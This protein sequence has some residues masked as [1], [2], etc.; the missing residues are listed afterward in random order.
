VRT[1]TLRV[2]GRA[3][4]WL[5][6]VVAVVLVAGCDYEV[7]G[8]SGQLDPAFGGGDGVVS[9]AGRARSDDNVMAAT[10]QPDGKLVVVTDTGGDFMLLRFLPGGDIDPGFGD[11]GV[12]HTA[13]PNGIVTAVTVM[14]DG[15]IALAGGIFG[16][17]SITGWL[18]AR[19]QPD[20]DP[21]PGF[22]NGG[23]ARVLPD[24]EPAVPFGFATDIV[25][26]GDDIVIAAIRTS[27]GG[28]PRN[29]GV[30][31]KL[32]ADGTIDTSFGPDGTGTVIVGNASRGVVGALPD[33]SFVA[34]SL[35]DGGPA[36]LVL[37][38]ATGVASPPIGL[39]AGS[40]TVVGWDDIAVAGDGS[41]VV[42]GTELVFPNRSAVLVKLAPD[43]TLDTGFGAG[44]VAPVPL[45]VGRQASV[46]V[47]AG[48]LVV[49]A[50]TVAPDRNVQTARVTDAG[51]LD[52]AWGDGGMATYD[53]TESG[54]AVVATGEGVLVI[55]A[56]PPFSAG[57]GPSD[58]LL[59]A[60]D[61][62][63]AV[64]P[65]F[66]D[67]GRVAYDI[68][69]PGFDT[70]TVTARLPGGDILVAGDTR[71]GVVAGR[72]DGHGMPDDDHPVAPLLPGRLAGLH[73]VRDLAVAPDGSAFLL[74]Q[75]GDQ[76]PAAFFGGGGT[77]WRVVKLAPGGEIDTS[78]GDGGV[79]VHDGGS[80]PNAIA[81]QP[82]GTVLVAWTVIH[83][84]RLIPPHGVEPATFDFRIDALTPS[85]QPDTTFGTGGSLLHPFTGSPGPPGPPFTGWMAVGP[86][87]TAYLS[88]VGL[89]RVDP[90]GTAFTPGA[91]AGT[92]LGAT[93]VAIDPRGGVV[94]T[95]RA[96]VG[97]T[98]GVDVV[99]R[100]NADLT[101]LDPAF[102]TA[103]LAPL[104]PTL[105]GQVL[106][107]P[108]LL[109]DDHGVVTV[110][111]QARATGL[112][113][114]DLVIRRMTARGVPDAGFSSDGLAVGAFAPGGETA[115]VAGAALVGRDVV[116]VGRFTDALDGMVAR[117]NG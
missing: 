58:V 80:F 76:E 3:S 93:D 55:G 78:F 44:G 29:D 13:I 68:G 56:T 31:A 75:V 6:A 37:V 27:D 9:F 5:A 10:R 87:G 79:A 30:V 15:D 88:G 36:G 35:V 101:A 21:D 85:G 95:G 18:V 52:P 99:A 39:P 96:T 72:Y 47:T 17:G 8:E 66:G 43:R 94:L 2:A 16:S 34:S 102:G 19:Y 67:G 115:T 116:V 38:S 100:A 7:G 89:S 74:V 105:P 46:A 69:Q 70:L 64:D 48:G 113:Y 106:T 84:P 20:G 26:A 54:V 60:V 61:D 65:T 114:D 86:D 11:G 82:D 90:D 59:L 103:G 83:P 53:R 111:S 71:D 23:I 24:L 28:Q 62:A 14:P 91:L 12:V 112:G 117:V 51:A 41:V 50:D 33:G 81:L 63:G 107:G 57:L 109:V 73:T 40:P 97:G 108:M 25:P 77:G 22:G 104:P 4:R 42:A 98:S 49:Q 45:L 1:S 110:V 32:L 92:D